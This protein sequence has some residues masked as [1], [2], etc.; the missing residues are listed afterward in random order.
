MKTVATCL[1]IAVIITAV[2][3]KMG[4]LDEI[5]KFLSFKKKE[6]KENKIKP[7]EMRNDYYEIV[8]EDMR[9]EYDKALAEFEAEYANKRKPRPPRRRNATPS[10]EL[11]IMCEGCLQEKYYPAHLKCRSCKYNE[12][13]VVMSPK[14]GDWSN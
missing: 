12:A 7:L 4:K 8:V 6:E 10:N 14:R 11:P 1:A 9:R 2:A 13:D 5:N 3:Q